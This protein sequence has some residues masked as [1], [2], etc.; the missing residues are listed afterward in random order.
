MLAGPGTG[1]THTLAHRLLYLVRDIGL[2]PAR[3]ILVLSFSRAAVAEIRARLELLAGYGATD[4]IRFINVRTFDSFATRLLTAAG[5]GLE[6]QGLGYD[7]RIQRA[8]ES[9]SA[10][11]SEANELLADVRHLV[12]DEIQDLVTVRARLVMQLIQ[13]LPGGFTLLGDPAQAIYD[14]QIKRPSDKPTSLEF[15]EWAKNPPGK[16]APKLMTLETNRRTKTA[17]AGVADQVRPMALDSETPGLELYASLRRL[18]S[19]LPEAGSVQA[20]N[21][22]RLKPHQKRVAV[23]C[24]TN[25]QALFTASA[26]M[27]HGL[28]CVVPPSVEDRGLPAWIARVF[29][30]FKDTRISPEEFKSRWFGLVGPDQPP[31]PDAAW[32]MLSNLVGGDQSMLDLNILRARLRDGADWTFDSE[33]FA[34]TNSVLVTTIHQSKGREFDCVAILQP[35]TRPAN[36]QREQRAEARVLYVAATRARSEILQLE[37]AGLPVLDTQPQ[38][39]H[40]SR[41][42]GQDRAGKHYFQAGVPGDLDNLSWVERELH[43]DLAQVDK[44]QNLIWTKLTPGT[45]LQVAAKSIRGDVRLV[46]LRRTADQRGYYA[47]ALFDQNCKIDLEDLLRRTSSNGTAGFLKIMEEVVV[48]ERTTVILPPYLASIYEPYATSGFC[49]GLTVSGV[50]QVD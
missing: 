30:T 38:R 16:P 48:I 41:Q 49:L 28:A 10:S 11:D 34:T 37:N 8:I 47:L 29:S 27:R 26:L 6:L 44:I 1:K 22:D 18:V 43:P 4:D 5:V 46:L 31:G 14:F 40:R 39:S 42:I 19:D 24:R 33:A 25:A 20:P 45:R 7:A 9:L 13:S 35:Q 36:N 17:A 32:R 2:A 21:I 3:E 15:L 12:V 50:L 23:L